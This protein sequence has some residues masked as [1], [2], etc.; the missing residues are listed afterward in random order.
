MASAVAVVVG[1]MISGL[2]GVLVVFFQQR[3]ARPHEIAVARAAR[4]SEF[5][6]AGWALTLAITEL[7]SAHMGSKGNLENTERL[8]QLTDRFNSV[9][10]QIQLL[11]T[12][13]VYAS[14]HGVDASLVELR[15]AAR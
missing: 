7:A 4:L 5:S 13:D 1:A 8:Q 15:Q 14:A 11:D 2:I 10:A 12:G 9:L 6:A 3:L